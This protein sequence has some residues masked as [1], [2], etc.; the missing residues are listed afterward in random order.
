MFLKVFQVGKTSAGKI[1]LIGVAQEVGE[2]N[3][4]PLNTYP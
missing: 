1:S 3:E 2:I 4:I